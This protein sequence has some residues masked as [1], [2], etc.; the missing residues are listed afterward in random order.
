[1]E[2]KFIRQT[3]NDVL[4]DTATALVARH[5]LRAYDAVQLAGCLVLRANAAGDEPS[6]VCSDQRL[7]EAAQAEGL[8]CLDPTAP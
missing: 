6:F 1:M 2:S 4:I 3:M 7:L 5:L 8:L